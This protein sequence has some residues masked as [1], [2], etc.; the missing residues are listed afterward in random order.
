MVGV[1]G[2]ELDILKSGSIRSVG[3]ASSD[4]VEVVVD[5]DWGFN[6]YTTENIIA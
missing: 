6:R 4:G 1:G 3:G 2:G 5:A